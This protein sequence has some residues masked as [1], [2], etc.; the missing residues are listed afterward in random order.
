MFS[1][2]GIGQCSR[3]FLIIMDPFIALRFTPSQTSTCSPG[4]SISNTNINYTPP[5]L[6]D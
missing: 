6:I 5:Q 4:S 2:K 1:S 3:C